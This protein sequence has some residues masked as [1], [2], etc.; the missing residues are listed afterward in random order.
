MSFLILVSIFFIS[1]G[2]QLTMLKQYVTKAIANVFI[3]SMRF[4]E[5]SFLYCADSMI[6]FFSYLFLHLA[7]LDSV[8]FIDA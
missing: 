4:A 1:D 5:L 2:V 7:M 8:T 3:A 6:T